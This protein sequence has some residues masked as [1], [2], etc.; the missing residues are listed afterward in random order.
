MLV[1]SGIEAFDDKEE[2]AVEDGEDD[3]EKGD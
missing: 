3:E 2:R 1:R